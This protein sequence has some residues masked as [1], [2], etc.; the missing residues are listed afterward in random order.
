MICTMETT[1]SHN[2]KWP[3]KTDLSAWHRR[4]CSLMM[5]IALLPI[6]QIVHAE[7]KKEHMIDL[8]ALMVQAFEKPAL[9]GDAEAQF[10]LGNLY[11]N[12]NEIFPQD[13]AK[14]RYWFEQAAAQN[15]AMAQGLLGIFYYYGYGVKQDFTQ[16][17]QWFEK[18]AAQG[19]PLSQFTLGVIYM[20]GYGVTLDYTQARQWF[21]KSAAQKEQKA[22]Y[23]LG[24][25]YENGYGVPQNLSK[26]RRWYKLA[27]AQGEEKAQACLDD[28]SEKRRG[29]SK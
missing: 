22:Q 11:G 23:H 20:S 28:L 7:N 12:G 13:Y 29:R 9:E 21:E 15:H 3:S 17:R 26:A 27:A 24:I 4:L 6:A 5:L 25:M 8:A 10:T 18:A 19:E 16:A 1:A 14:A 2:W